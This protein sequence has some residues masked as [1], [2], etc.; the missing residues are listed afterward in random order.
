MSEW[1]ITEDHYKKLV[2]NDDQCLHGLAELQTQIRLVVRLLNGV[3]AED[4][5]GVRPRLMLVE[6]RVNDIPVDLMAQLQR[7][8][9]KIET[10]TGEWNKLKER[11]N[12]AKWVLGILGVTNAATL[13]ILARFLTG[14][15]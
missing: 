8:N 5:P 1:T 15:N 9:E 6:R 2:T 4:V 14:T 7:S 13:G 11:Y 10:L 12:G 3:P